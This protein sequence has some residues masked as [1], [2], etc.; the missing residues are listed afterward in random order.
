MAGEKSNDLKVAS[1]EEAP[2]K[3]TIDQTISQAVL[4]DEQQ[5]ELRR[6][7]DK[8]VL[9]IICVLYLFS[10]LDRSNIGNAKTA[11]AQIDLGLSSSQV[12]RDLKTHNERSNIRTSGHGFST[13]C[14][15]PMSYSNGQHSSG[16]FSQHTSTFRCSVSAGG[17]QGFV[18]EL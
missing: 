12:S 4:S 17:L 18:L 15:S 11:G 10:Y 7:F 1:L 9:P 6:K 3:S 5:K 16:R 14:T 8:R 13:L 2:E